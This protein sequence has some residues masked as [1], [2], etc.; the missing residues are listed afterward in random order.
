V[1]RLFFHPL[2]P[3]RPQSSPAGDGAAPIA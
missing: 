2:A 3:G 1:R